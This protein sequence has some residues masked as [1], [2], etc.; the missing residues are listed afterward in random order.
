MQSARTVFVGG[1]SYWDGPGWY[2]NPYWDMYGFIPGDGIWYSPF[3]WPFYSPWVLRVRIWIWLSAGMAMAS[4]RGSR[5]W[6]C[7]RLAP[8]LQAAALLV[9]AR[10]GRRIRRARVRRW[11]ARWIRR[12]RPPLVE[13][14]KEGSVL[15]NEGIDAFGLKLGLSFVEGLAVIERPDQHAHQLRPRPGGNVRLQFFARG[16]VGQSGEWLPGSSAPTWM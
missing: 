8:S 4:V 9:R 3:G 16:D 11:N 14:S 10:D 5:A 13:L 1:G 2:W 7:E 15:S 12:W 6:A